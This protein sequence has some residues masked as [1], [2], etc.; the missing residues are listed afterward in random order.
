MRKLLVPID[1]SDN[2]A[3][4]LDFAASL[5]AAGV[6][7]TIHLL[8]IC[9][10]IPDGERSHAFHSIAELEVPLR[11]H[12]EAVLKTAAE[13]VAACGA[14]IVPEIAAGTL[15]PTIVARAQALGCHGI[16]MGR[17]GHSLV[18]ELL[19]GSTTMAVLHGTN[20]PLTLV[21]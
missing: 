17:K 8:T 19:L 2:A 7:L 13:R 5:A 11:A 14:E 16:V 12:C 20:L 3:R 1:G 4:A 10:P 15:A 6:P 9:E 21:R 18:A